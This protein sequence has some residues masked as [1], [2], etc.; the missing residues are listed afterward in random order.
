MRIGV[1]AVALLGGLAGPAG[2]DGASDL[3]R[4]LQALHA[5]GP[6][7]ATVRLELR[8]ERTMH[9]QTTDGQASVRLDVD[10]DSRGIRIRWER[11]VLQEADEEERQD[12]AS[13]DRLLPGLGGGG[14]VIEEPAAGANGNYHLD[15]GWDKGLRFT[16]PDD[17]TICGSSF[18]S[19]VITFAKSA[20]PPARRPL[21]SERRSAI[22]PDWR[23]ASPICTAYF[24]QLLVKPRADV[25]SELQTMSIFGPLKYQRS[26]MMSAK[27]SV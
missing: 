10:E 15:A 3:A 2:A 8:L 7:A 19:K 24:R 4:R 18:G 26:S 11:A 12:D 1:Y 22:S 27:P 21:S 16:S 25:A 14:V 13:P 5:P 23:N 20:G 17:Q 6:V 9:H